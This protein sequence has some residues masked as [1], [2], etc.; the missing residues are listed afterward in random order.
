MRFNKAE[1][2]EPTLIRSKIFWKEGQ[3]R[4]GGG[5]VKHKCSTK[6][7]IVCKERTAKNIKRRG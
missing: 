2:E 6:I 4:G 7:K 5:G 3:R 1:K